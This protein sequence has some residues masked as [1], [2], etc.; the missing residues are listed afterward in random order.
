MPHFTGTAYQGGPSVPDPKLQWVLLTATGGH[1]GADAQH[2]AIRRWVAPQDGV[3]SV[4]GALGHGSKEGDG[5]EARIVS[6]GHGSLGVWTAHDSKADTN[7]EKVSVKKGDTLDFVVSCRSNHNFDSFT[8]SNVIAMEGGSAVWDST[9]QFGG[10]PE[11]APQPLTAWARYVQALLMTNEF[12][13][14]D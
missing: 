3:V 1:V 5:V 7:V 14:V 6:N 8:W 10:P 13:F 9:V 4:K 2:A 11:S 12:V